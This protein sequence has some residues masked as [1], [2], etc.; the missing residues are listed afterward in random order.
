MLSFLQIRNYAIVDSLELE[1]VEGFS[2]ITGE[3]GA[4]KSILVGA[5]GL[6]CGDRADTAAIRDGAERAELA[7]GFELERGKSALCWLTENDLD[8][9]DSCLLRRVINRNG[10]SRAWINGT[11]VTIQ[12]LSEL[13]RRLVE[14]HGQNEHLRLASNR[15]QFRVLDEGGKYAEQMTRTRDRYHDWRQ[16]EQEKQALLQET[17]L[18]AAEQD[19]LDYQVRELQDN[20]LPPAELAE[21]ENEHRK[22]AR[23]GDI[24]SVLQS[25]LDMLQAEDGGTVSDIYR[26]AAK[27]QE[28]AALDADISAAAQLLNEAAINCDEAC[29]S[30]QAA[31]SRLDLSPERLAE[32][33]ESLTR[34]HDLARKHRVQP[35]QLQQVLDQLLWRLEHAATLEKRLARIDA[36]LDAA[37]LAYRQA[38]AELH[39]KRAERAASLSSEVTALMQELGMQGGCFSID[40]H[41]DENGSPS[42]RGDDR[43][44][45]LVSANSGHA[46][47]P[48]QKVASGG[49]LS[50]ISL[51]VKV[52]AR[53]GASAPTQV[54][55]EVDA[56]IGGE[57]ARAVGQ[58]LKSLSAGKQALCV[59]HLAQVAVYADRQIR[60]SKSGGP[61]GSRV[62]LTVLG[63]EDRVD[64]V[65]RMLG[66]Q[67]SDQSRAHASELLGEASAIIH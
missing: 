28:H 2:C 20:M 51:A 44:A 7:A 65:A 41:H 14:I 15:E 63:Q 30:V 22:L 47:G 17:P 52:A 56:G 26:C 48:L 12:Q 9:G 45:F 36:D 32:L 55:D 33:Q 54:F 1:F 3:T 21:L 46:P 27:L 13:G 23:G 10:R 58:L 18:D 39:G 64:E 37:L 57:T 59:T 29:A 19:L 53:Q 43:L 60:V 6:L 8:D 35:D 50:R 16:L 49:E 25:A 62:E 67:L 61:A 24:Q 34:Q 5:L 66:G 38:A 31:L 40:I 42:A 4:G 11:P